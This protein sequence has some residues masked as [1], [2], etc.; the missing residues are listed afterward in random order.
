MKNSTFTYNVYLRV[1]TE[2]KV[3]YQLVKT[4]KVMRSSENTAREYVYNKY[5]S[6]TYFIERQA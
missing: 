5:P 3:S 1:T 4:M 6:L 2:G